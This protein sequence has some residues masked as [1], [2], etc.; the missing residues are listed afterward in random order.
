LY[1]VETYDF[2]QPGSFGEVIDAAIKDCNGIVFKTHYLPKNIDT[3]L[4][5]AEV[6]KKIA[7]YDGGDRSIAQFIID[8]PEKNSEIEKIKNHIAK[9]GKHLNGL[10]LP[11]GSDIEPEIYG[12]IPD[13]ITMIYPNS[14]TD[15][16]YLRTIFEIALLDFAD[17]NNRPVLGICRGSQ[18]ANVFFGG[19]IDQDC[20]EIMGAIRALSIK[21][22]I[23]K[24]VAR[25][26]RSILNGEYIFT[27]SMHHQASQE[28]GKGL[29]VAI[30]HEGIPKLIIGN[31][32]VL[33]QFHPEIFKLRFVNL[34]DILGNN[35]NFFTNLIERANAQ[36][37]A[38]LM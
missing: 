26:A 31:N 21:S 36:M 10:T 13:P 7:E 24:E 2:E 17:K 16:T 11:G 14:E 12:A 33:T 27:L 4:L 23:D 9:I 18:L 30:E 6:K 35:R 34:I 3:D 20:G 15:P 25:I 29:H 28:I 1:K 5:D 32:C 19:T 22:G 38:S 8:N 37:Y